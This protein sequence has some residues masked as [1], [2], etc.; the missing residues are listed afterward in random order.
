MNHLENKSICELFIKML[1]D[2]AERN[3]SLP[4]IPDVQA[5]LQQSGQS[6]DGDPQKTA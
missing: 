3:Q 1:N 4:G 5:V 2:L 6:G